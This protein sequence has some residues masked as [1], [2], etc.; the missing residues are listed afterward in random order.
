MNSKY[1]FRLYSINTISKPNTN[2]QS[3]VLNNNWNY[4]LYMDTYKSTTAVEVGEKVVIIGDS[5]VGKTS[6]IKWYVE[7]V[8]DND[9]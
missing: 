6:I 4:N 8:F 5:S 2:T 1:L 9:F 3:I 7:N